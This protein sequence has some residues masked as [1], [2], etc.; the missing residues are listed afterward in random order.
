MGGY[1]E[2]LQGGP[3]RYTGYAN[4]HEI[5][6]YSEVWQQPCKEDEVQLI[7]VSFPVPNQ[8]CIVAWR[9]CRQMGAI[10]HTSLLRINCL[11]VR[12][13]ECAQMT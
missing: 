10:H 12:M 4:I 2:G 13:Q 3:A 1:G 6:Y 9:V 5:V 8:V 7:L 11:L